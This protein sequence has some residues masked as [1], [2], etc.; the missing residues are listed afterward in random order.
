MK[1]PKA[2]CY[3]GYPG[4]GKSQAVQAGVEAIGGSAVSMGDYIR[5]FYREDVGDD[6]D[7]HSL[8]QYATR[9]RERN[10]P[11][12]L[13]ARMCQEWDESGTP[14]LPVHIDGLRCKEGHA[15]FTSFFG[16]VPIIYLQAGFGERHRRMRNRG[17][18]GE[19]RFTREDLLERDRREAEWGTPLLRGLDET[20]IVPNHHT[21]EILESE[22]STVLH[23]A[24]LH[25]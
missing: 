12:G 5:R 7:S 14:K 3:A 13:A 17:R 19:D 22:I 20:L 25:N 8:G 23:E 11:E 10:G 1:V 6:T 9:F 15:E 16:N 4:A 21:V 18:E 24:I 2:I